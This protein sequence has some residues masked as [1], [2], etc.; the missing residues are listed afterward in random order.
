MVTILG[1]HF[2]TVFTVLVVL[3]A[4]GAAALALAFDALL[5]RHGRHRAVRHQHRP[6]HPARPA[7]RPVQRPFRPR[8]GH[9]ARSGHAH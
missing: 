3:G 2:W 4:L 9:H 8:V 6:V 7:P 5:T 1:P